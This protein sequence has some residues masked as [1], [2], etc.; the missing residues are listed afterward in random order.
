M[1]I[2]ATSRVLTA[3]AVVLLCGCSRR[4][5]SSSVPPPA[6]PPDPRQVSVFVKN[7]DVV[8]YSRIDVWEELNASVPGDTDVTHTICEPVQAFGTLAPPFESLGCLATIFMDE[9]GTTDTY[10]VELYDTTGIFL[11]VVLFSKPAGRIDLFV[12][13]SGGLFT[14]VIVSPI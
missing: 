13:I 2:M 9:T 6:P 14:E 7:L 5:S 8:E 1:R 11:D 12:T 3:I 4:S 10:T